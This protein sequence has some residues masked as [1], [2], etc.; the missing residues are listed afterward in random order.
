[1]TLRMLVVAPLLL[2]AACSREQEPKGK[3][4][5]A[6]ASA[7]SNTAEAVKTEKKSIE[8]AADAAAKLIEAEAQEEIESLNNDSSQ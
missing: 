2:V 8:E 7:I 5:P 4:E 6:K 1:M 3:P